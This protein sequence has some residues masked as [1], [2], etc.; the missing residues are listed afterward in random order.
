[1]GRGRGGTSRGRFPR[2]VAVGAGFL[3]VGTVAGH[4]RSRVIEAER[5]GGTEIHTPAAEGAPL[6]EVAPVHGLVGVVRKGYGRRGANVSTDPAADAPVPVVK[7]RAAI[8]IREW[9]R[10]I[11]QAC[12][13]PVP[14]V[15]KDDLQY[16]H[17]YFL[18]RGLQQ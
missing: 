4:L 17:L 3:V 2:V 18:T 1:M 16:S 8:V 9:D 5:D 14:Q 13:R 6:Y 11:D 15:L 7:D 12:A 10:I